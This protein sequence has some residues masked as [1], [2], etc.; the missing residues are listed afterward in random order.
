MS[1]R[2]ANWSGGRY[3]EVVFLVEAPKGLTL[4]YN[5]KAQTGV[6]KGEGYTLSGA[7][8][9]TNAGSY[10]A[11]ATLDEHYE[12]S[13]G[14]TAPK[15]ISW[16]I[17]KAAAKVTAPT[18][19]TYT[20]NGKA[21]TGVAA[22]SKYTLSGTVKATKAGSY[23]AKAALKA[24]ANYTY[25]WSDGTTAVKTIKWKI[26]KAANTLTVK[27]KTTKVKYK[28]LKKKAQKLD[29]TNVISFT[30]AG[31]GTKTYKLVSVKKGKKNF[32]KKISIDSKTGKVTIKKKL[33]KGTYNV[34]VN[35]KAGGNVN[36]KASAWK[37]VTFKIKVK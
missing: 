14:T 37:A 4:K 29:V 9:A 25:T 23:T 21:Q 1:G 3:I 5:G 33:K 13:D 24:N 32:D 20:Y 10:Q 7:V 6:Q 19:K 26:N 22:G 8:S 34:K 36:Y 18:G 27:G 16:K 17:N 12:W 35:V 15:T 2:H 31:Q 11:T 28:K 30:K